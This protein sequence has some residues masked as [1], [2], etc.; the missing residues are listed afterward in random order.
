MSQQANITVFDGASTP[1]SHTLNPVDNK[2]LKDGTRVAIYRENLPTL[3][4]EAQVR[5]EIYQRE[6]ANKVVE[7][8]TAVVV[9]VMETVSGQNAAGYTAAPKI[10]Y[11]DKAVYVQY[12]HRRSTVAS[13]R[14]AAQILRNLVSNVAT[15]V[16]PVQAGP[17]DEAAVQLFMPT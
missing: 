8:R 5:V 7:T 12:A 6:L 14:L 15:T 13:R 1:V 4:V 16:T 10:A 3:P 9:P 17:V 11:E 2:V